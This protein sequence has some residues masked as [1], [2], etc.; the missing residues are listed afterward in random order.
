MSFFRKLFGGG[1]SSGGGAAKPVA[2]TTHKGYQILSTPIP[3][4][5]QFRVC[6]LIRKEIEGEMREHK[7]IRGFE[8]LE[9]ASFHWIADDRFRGAIA[10]FLRTERRGV[11][12]SGPRRTSRSVRTFESC[13][14]SSR[15]PPPG[16]FGLSLRAVPR[17]RGERRRSDPKC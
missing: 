4:D 17:A 15:R 16:R 5:G 12:P 3:E 11:Q 8:P 14:V 2:E 7:L 13:L 10:D 1:E 9:T 6:A